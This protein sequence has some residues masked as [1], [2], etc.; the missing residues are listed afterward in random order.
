MAWR[1]KEDRTQKEQ[2]QELR[3]EIEALKQLTSRIPDPNARRLAT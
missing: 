2:I 3:Q 1:G